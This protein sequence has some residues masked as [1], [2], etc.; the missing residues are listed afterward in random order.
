MN[1]ARRIRVMLVDDQNLVRQGVRS[2]LELT[3]DI[4]VVAEATD[5]VEA[6]E[7]PLPVGAPNHA[8]AVE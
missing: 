6:V 8:V 2:L 4:E 3:E 7:A 5:G 1:E